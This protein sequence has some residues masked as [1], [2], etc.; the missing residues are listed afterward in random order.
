MELSVELKRLASENHGWAG[1]IF[2]RRLLRANKVNTTALKSFIT[3]RREFYIRK[4]KRNIV[5]ATR[6][7]TRLHG[8]FATIYAAGAL[9]IKYGILPFKRKAL[10]QAILKCEADHVAFVEQGDIGGGKPPATSLELLRNFLRDHRNYFADL[11]NA[12]AEIQSAPVYISQNNGHDEFLFR[13][14]R[15]EEIVGG[16]NEADNLKTLLAQQGL[17]RTAAGNKGKKRHVVRQT[18][19]KKRLWLVAIDAKVLDA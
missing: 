5:S 14:Y 15:L 16:K 13:N 7:L 4:A 8:K 19:G 6:D 12:N 1:R 11:S 17:L 2:V 3:K 18:I 10:R 9:A